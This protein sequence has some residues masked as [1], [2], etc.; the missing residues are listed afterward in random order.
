MWTTNEQ[1]LLE[2]MRESLKQEKLIS[3]EFKRG[4]SVVEVPYADVKAGRIPE[5]QAVRLR[6]AANGA[7]GK[8][9]ESV[10]VVISLRTLR[11]DRHPNVY[12][13]LLLIHAKMNKGGR[14]SFDANADQAWIPLTRLQSARQDANAD[15][16]AYLVG[17]LNRYWRFVTEESVKLNSDDNTAWTQYLNEA[18]RLYDAVCETRASQLSDGFTIIS[19]P[20][21]VQAQEIINATEAIEE[22]YQDVLDH[23][24]RTPLLKHMLNPQTA[25]TQHQPAEVL[26]HKQL[27]KDAP[28]D[29]KA[30]VAAMIADRASASLQFPP[31]DSQRVA[32]HHFCR[33]P[34]GDVLAL[35][36]PPGTGKTATL[37]SMI[38]NE[39]VDHAL[40]EQSAP[41]IVGTSANN[42]AVTN[43][44]ESFSTVA[45]KNPG[46]LDV[47]WLPRVDENGKL[48]GGVFQGLAT[49]FPSSAKI[50][51][52]KKNGY[53]YELRRGKAMYVTY[54]DPDYVRAA[55]PRFIDNARRTPFLSTGVFP[56]NAD[57]VASLR[58]AILGGLK[59]L[60]KLRVE[61]IEAAHQALLTLPDV[62][63]QN[64]QPAFGL[65]A[66]RTAG[67]IN[68]IASLRILTD[69]QVK[70][71]RMLCAPRGAAE[72]SEDP[73]FKDVGCAGDVYRLID[74]ALDTT[75]RECEFWLAVH[76]YEC[77]WFLAC[78]NDETF[79]EGDKEYGYAYPKRD[80]NDRFWPQMASLTPM[81]VMT[82]AKL[83]S[84][85]RN[86]EKTN[87]HKGYDFGRIDML[88]VDEAG[89]IPTPLGLAAFALAKKAV[90]TGDVLQIAPVWAFDPDTDED[91]SSNSY[92]DGQLWESMRAYGLTASEPSS[93]MRLASNV[94]PW[95]SPSDNPEDRGLFLSEHYRCVEE[96]IEYCNDLLYG[97]RLV[98]SRKNKH[99]E[100]QL[101][102]IVGYPLTYRFVQGS[103]SQTQ[104]GS[105][106]NLQEAKAIARWIA[107]HKDVLTER[108]AKNGATPAIG[109]VVA[110]VT[111]F[112]AQAT[113]ITQEL[114]RTLGNDARGIVCGTA[115]K[116]QGAERPVVLY[117]S[118]YGESDPEAGFVEGNPNLMNVAVSRAK[119]AF[120]MF[121]APRRKK[122]SKEVM[123]KYFQFAQEMLEDDARQHEQED[124]G[125]NAD[126]SSEPAVTLST[127]DETA[128]PKQ[129]ATQSAEP[130]TAPVPLAPE[131]VEAGNSCNTGGDHISAPAPAIQVQTVA[132]AA[133]SA[134]ASAPITSTAVR[135]DGKVSL[136]TLLRFL[137]EEGLLD[138]TMTARNANPLLADK[139][140]L[141]HTAQG[142]W[143]P[144]AYGSRLG[145]ETISNDE[146]KMWPVYPTNLRMLILG[147]L[148]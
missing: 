93:L 131:T 18:N 114:E 92:I 13:A 71:L 15:Q 1:R 68:Q 142:Y 65:I 134:A 107:E 118:V 19:D 75:V 105:R 84:F 148:L 127:V 139:G 111:P 59:A 61:L 37:Q 47:R 34:E 31:A 130:E 143:V 8:P 116:L 82:E 140:L 69:D 44:I 27:E 126:V 11:D 7:T 66:D 121:C 144:T 88:V 25:I 80:V 103:Q 79:D 122:D 58:S 112:S 146:G 2:Y 104:N 109:D 106:F 5:A 30:T 73:Q 46:P 23:P 145:I 123:R 16:E 56:A 81:M 43:L 115:H 42:Q 110:V 97:G 39:L 9:K 124:L 36:G 41:V 17:S 49:Y 78:L 52:A 45:D 89:Q 50:N 120:V 91:F 64:K 94:T 137:H 67:I 38:G 138:K 72:E 117:S 125:F 102:D 6:K 136:T 135:N 113:R 63:E 95:D 108:Y 21:Y 57:G 76:Y 33:M 3:T 141:V 133:S 101:G 99:W 54:S 96:I 10:E 85:F 48:D 132:P 51:E 22:L 35:S 24:G 129:E 12:E 86:Y 4:D 83:P 53:P 128:E 100:E 90:V 20:C 77:T 62:D 26:E 55:V 60:D 70:R 32:I 98:P 14:L 29:A 147:I 28:F 87:N 119:D 40:R 74:R